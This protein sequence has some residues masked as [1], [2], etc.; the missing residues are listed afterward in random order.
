MLTNDEL[1]KGI[2]LIETL[3]RMVKIDKELRF[4]GSGLWD[5]HHALQGIRDRFTEILQR[6]ESKKLQAWNGDVQ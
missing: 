6:R 1:A 4:Y 3:D 5:T 2:E